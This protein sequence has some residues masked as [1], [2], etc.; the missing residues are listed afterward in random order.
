MLVRWKHS[1]LLLG[2]VNP[3]NAVSSFRLVVIEQVTAGGEGDNALE[4][5]RAAEERGERHR[6]PL[7]WAERVSH[8]CY[9]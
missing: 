3:L 5:P 9:G 8:R 4:A 1:M 7:P 2:A 6:V